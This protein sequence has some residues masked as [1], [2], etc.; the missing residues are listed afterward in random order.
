MEEIERNEQKLIAEELK[1]LLNNRGWI[2]LVERLQRNVDELQKLILDDIYDQ[3][4]VDR[5]S[6]MNI[7]R[8]CDD[9]LITMPQKW[10]KAIDANISQNDK[11][12]EN[13]DPYFQYLPEQQ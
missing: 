11:E 6:K 12:P 5:K 2:R 9:R 10:I 7:E 4:P 13:K 8:F 3:I 1:S